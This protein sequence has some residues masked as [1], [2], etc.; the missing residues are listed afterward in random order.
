MRL[1]RVLHPNRGKVAWSGYCDKGGAGCNDRLLTCSVIVSYYNISF[2][3]WREGKRQRTRLIFLSQLQAS[4][5][6]LG[7]LPSVVHGNLRGVTC[8]FFSAASCWSRNKTLFKLIG[9][10]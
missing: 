8:T 6:D 5:G 2:L 10:S 3:V 4:A 7:G 1:N 9:T